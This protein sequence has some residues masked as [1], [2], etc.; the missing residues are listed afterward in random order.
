MGCWLG[1]ARTCSCRDCRRDYR[2]KTEREIATI[3]GCIPAVEVP[4]R[5]TGDTGTSPD[6]IEEH[7]RKCKL[8]SAKTKVLESFEEYATLKGDILKA[9]LMQKIKSLLE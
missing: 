3:K 6:P 5:I 2:D 7:T 8:D 1:M 9:D 4:Q